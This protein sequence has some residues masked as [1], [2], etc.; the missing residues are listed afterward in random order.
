LPFCRELPR[1]FVSCTCP[2]DPNATDASNPSIKPPTPSATTDGPLPFVSVC[3][4]LPGVVCVGDPFEIDYPNDPLP[5]QCALYGGFH[6]AS[7]L[8]FSVFLGFCGVDRFYLGYCFLGIVKLLT[9]GGIGI[10]WAVDT[11][12]LIAGVYSP[13]DS[14]LWE[15]RW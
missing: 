6:F 13:A 5:A 14:F 11:A 9:L 2:T 3:T 8:L 15:P 1:S 4:A 12:L 10:W 7:A